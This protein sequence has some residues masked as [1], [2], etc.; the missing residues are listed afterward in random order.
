M[1]PRCYLSSKYVLNVCKNVRKANI[2]SIDLQRNVG[3]V[4]QQAVEGSTELAALHTQYADRSREMAIELQGSLQNMRDQEIN[5]M[6]SVFNGIHSQLVRTPSI[7][8]TRKH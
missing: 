4:F 6:L 5:A 7:F 8:L 1:C 3:K 2:E